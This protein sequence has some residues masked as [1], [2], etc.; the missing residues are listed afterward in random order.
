[1]ISNITHNHLDH[2]ERIW[3]CWYSH[4]NRIMS[5]TLES[6]GR[7]SLHFMYAGKNFGYNNRYEHNSCRGNIFLY[8][9][10]IDSIAAGKS[11]ARELS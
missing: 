9:I 1:M 8:V 4:G 2:S 10:P 3:L 6:I 11:S 7:Y 5:I